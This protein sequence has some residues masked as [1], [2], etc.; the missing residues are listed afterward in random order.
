MNNFEIRKQT[1]RKNT[2]S[3]HPGIV[4]HILRQ[5]QCNSEKEVSYCK[6]RFLLFHTLLHNNYPAAVT[7]D[8]KA[9]GSGFPHR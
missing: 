9:L 1:S 3:K 2:N 6:N 8:S 4:I 5:M 7:R